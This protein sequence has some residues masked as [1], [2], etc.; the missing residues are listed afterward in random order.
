MP[1][2]GLAAAS[3]LLSLAATGANLDLHPDAVLGKPDFVTPPQGIATSINLMGPFATAE[4]PA[5][6]ELWVVDEAAHRVLRYASAS[7]F[8]SGEA[9]NL[10]LGQATLSGSQ[11]NRGGLPAANTLQFPTAV[12]VDQAGRLYVADL[13]NN[14]VLRFRPP[15]SNG[16]A[17]SVVLGRRRG[18]GPVELHGQCLQSWRNP[19]PGHAVQSRGAR[20]QGGDLLRRPSLRRGPQQSPHR[21]H[22]YR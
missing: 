19:R 10:V 5:S 6:G 17:A 9:A 14:R 11:P 22:R 4:D 15:F 7:A 21:V 18:R 12:V 16:M 20:A 8:A 3:L 13:G 1:R 2:L